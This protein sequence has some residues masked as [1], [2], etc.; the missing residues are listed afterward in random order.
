MDLHTARQALASEWF[1]AYARAGYAAKGVSFGAVGFLMAR[2]ALGDTRERADFAGA[3]QEMSEQPLLAALLVLMCVGLVGYGT[4][5]L[6]QGIAD[7]EREG[8]DA[9]GL[10]KRAGYS[11]IGA[12]Y[13]GLAVYA[14]GI[15]FGWSTEE[16]A[17]RDLTATVLGWPGGR[18]LVGTGGAAVLASG[19]AELWFALSRRFQVELGRDDIRG[20]ER[21]S[22]LCTGCLGHAGRALV[23]S[24]A[25]IFTIRAALDFDPDEAR[26]V[27]ATIRELADQ[28]YGHALV[29]LAASGFVAYGI[30]YC[31]LSFHHHL[32]NEGLLRGRRGRGRSGEGAEQERTSPEASREP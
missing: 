4:W 24:A 30:Y 23:Y 27:A 17:V 12:V 13:L 18:W 26:G 11:L 15:L 21:I 10:L 19:L 20:L 3:M 32:P 9:V 25:G 2:V 22:L 7:V 29:A 6:I 5:R 14:I 28:P 8:S 31:L 16:G 1:D